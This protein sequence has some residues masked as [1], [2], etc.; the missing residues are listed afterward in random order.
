[1]NHISIKKETSERNDKNNWV[2]DRLC[3]DGCLL[4]SFEGYTIR[5]NRT[6]AL[7]DRR[8]YVDDCLEAYTHAEL[9][10]LI[11]HEEPNLDAKL[12]FARMLKVNYFYVFYRYN[13]ERVVMYRFAGDAYFS[14]S[15]EGFM[16]DAKRQLT[17]DKYI[18]SGFD[19]FG[20]QT[21]RVRDLKMSSKYMESAD[22]PAFD[23]VLRRHGTP[24]MGNLDGLLLTR[25][26]K[27]PAAIIE[28]Q[29]TNKISVARHCNNKYFGYSGD[30][31]GRN[32][33]DEQRWKVAHKLALDAGLPLLVIVWSPKE[34]DIKYKVI[35]DVVYSG[36]REGRTPGLIYAEKAIVNYSQLLQKLESL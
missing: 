31:G 29:T 25:G 5:Q 30:R 35:S 12:A 33:G 23:Q 17:S 20:D 7:F 1:M 11:R 36:D 22:L 21:M 16:P 18:F 8:V 24:W 10:A 27:M 15:E 28:F 13:P 32:K 26:T 34:Q 14:I 19:I 2:K 9:E 6:T 3:K 4:E